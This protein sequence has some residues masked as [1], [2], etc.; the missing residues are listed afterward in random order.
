MPP[1]Q[2]AAADTEITRRHATWPAGAGTRPDAAN[3]GAIVLGTNA[4][5]I[6]AAD[7][8]L[9]INSTEANQSG[10]GFVPGAAVIW[11]G[12][13]EPTTW[14]AQFQVSTLVKPSTA[15]TPGPLPV[16]VRNPNGIESPAA[17]FTFTQP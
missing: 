4:A 14:V 10:N 6:G 11:N 1:V 17:T 9:L 12:G 13:V 16:A 3:P 8:T 5:D 2:N 7:F 15:T